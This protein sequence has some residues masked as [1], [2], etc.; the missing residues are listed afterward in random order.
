[1]PFKRFRQLVGRLWARTH[2]HYGGNQRVAT[3]KPTEWG[4]GRGLQ[5]RA[6]FLEPTHPLPNEES[7]PE[8]EVQAYTLGGGLTIDD[9]EGWI[10]AENERSFVM[11]GEQ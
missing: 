11:W 4:A 3:T 8:Y 7:G 1:M 6:A 2:E 9:G 5:Q 10:R